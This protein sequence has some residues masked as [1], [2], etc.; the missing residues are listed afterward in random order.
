MSRGGGGGRAPVYICPKNHSGEPCPAPAAVTVHLLDAYVE[1]IILAELA[2]LEV[3]AHAGGSL[4]QA[5][6]RL[7]DAEAE[8]AAYLSAVSAADVGA[9]AFADG[10]RARKAVVDDAVAAVDRELAHQAVLPT[11]R[12]GAEAWSELVAGERNELARAL[13]GTVVVRRAGGR[14]S[15]TSLPDRVRVLANGA[16]IKLPARR[17]GEA[18]GIVPIPLPNP[19]EPGVLGV[20]TGEDALEAS[21]SAEKVRRGVRV[22]A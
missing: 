12:S 6:S 19:D 5:R 10:A 21:G 9:D 18:S 3:T 11:V 20:P 7:A 13:L 16:S 4:E 8:L 22:A 2:R 1:P 17:G 15:R 14:G